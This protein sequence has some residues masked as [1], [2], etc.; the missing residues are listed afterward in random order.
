MREDLK[1]WQNSEDFVF[2]RPS[3]RLFLCLGRCRKLI[4]CTI[5]L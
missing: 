1:V 3:A 4:K 5:R 2:K